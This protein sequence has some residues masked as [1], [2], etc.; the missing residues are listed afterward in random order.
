MSNG[1]FTSDD[2]VDLVLVPDEQGPVSPGH[3]DHTDGSLS[4]PSS[5]VELDELDRLTSC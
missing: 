2:Y 5:D 3:S 1:G 4:I